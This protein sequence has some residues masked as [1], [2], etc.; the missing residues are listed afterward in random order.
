MRLEVWPTVP[1]TAAE[2][3]EAAR[4]SARERDRRPA[5]VKKETKPPTLKQAAPVRKQLRGPWASG[6]S[7]GGPA[8]GSVTS[9]VFALAVMAAI[10]FALPRAF[11][12]TPRASLVPTGEL[13]VSL[14][15]RP[16]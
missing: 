14:P 4:Q 13:G 16:G 11:R 10:P 12:A 9:R 5:R 2:F 1:Q 8:A 6:G 3:N 7:A 15:E